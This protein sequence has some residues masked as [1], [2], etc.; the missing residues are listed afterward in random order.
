MLLLLIVCCMLLVFVVC[1]KVFVVFECCWLFVSVGGVAV[2]GRGLSLG[3]VFVC[4]C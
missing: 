1:L 2:V 3:F 4:C